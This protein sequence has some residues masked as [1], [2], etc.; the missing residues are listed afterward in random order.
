MKKSGWSSQ[1][2][3]MLEMQ[4]SVDPVMRRLRCQPSDSF[5]YPHTIGI[6]SSAWPKLENAFTTHGSRLSMAETAIHPS[7]SGLMK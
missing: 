2:T 5:P 6:R 1:N 3:T 4:K 7:R